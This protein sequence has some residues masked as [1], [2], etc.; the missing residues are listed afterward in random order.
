MFS[1][2]GQSTSSHSSIVTRTQAQY[3][4]PLFRLEGTLYVEG[5]FPNCVAS[6]KAV[7]KPE[8]YAK[9]S[10]LTALLP[11]EKL[12]TVLRSREFIALDPKG[13]NLVYS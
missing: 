6:V 7:A 8:L 9:G 12:V 3:R 2:A 5:S 1:F 13:Q 4:C 10:V 11:S